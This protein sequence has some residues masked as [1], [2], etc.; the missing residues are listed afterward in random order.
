MT[1]AYTEAF[2]G[3]MVWGD[4]IA[5]TTTALGDIVR[6]VDSQFGGLGIGWDLERECNSI[7]D[8]HH[9]LEAVFNALSLFTEFKPSNE[10]KAILGIFHTYWPTLHNHILSSWASGDWE[11]CEHQTTEG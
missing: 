8:M 10:A 7:I 3:P 11:F 1:H 2:E 9:R 4:T 5:E 6:V